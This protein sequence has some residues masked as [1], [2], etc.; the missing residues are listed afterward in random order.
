M[1]WG[2]VG[3]GEEWG[4]RAG[5]RVG[6]GGCCGVGGGVESCLLCPVG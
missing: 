5:V 1:E 3:D 6:G 2:G 4:V